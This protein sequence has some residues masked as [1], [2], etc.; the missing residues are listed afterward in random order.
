[1]PRIRHTCN[2]CRREFR[3]HYGLNHHIAKH[4]RC[5][6]C[7]IHFSERDRLHAHLSDAHP[8][9]EI[10]STI[11][12]HLK[13]RSDYYFRFPQTGFVVNRTAFNH[14]IRLYR[15]ELSQLVSLEEVRQNVQA[16]VLQ[17]WRSQQHPALRTQVTLAARIER[18]D[19]ED[20]IEVYFNTPIMT[21]FWS[22]ISRSH[23]PEL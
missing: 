10:V 16:G 22:K 1:M 5:G 8:A 3:H 13:Y 17:M 20:L 4:H 23:F 21:L 2:W 11:D 6:I 15:R 19:D 12:L 7:G 14:H 9:T 18:G